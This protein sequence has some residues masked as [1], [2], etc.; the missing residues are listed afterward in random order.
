MQ[1]VATIDQVSITEIKPEHLH[2]VWGLVERGL[3]DVLRKSNLR[4]R[5]AD[6]IPADVYASIRTAQSTL[7]LVSRKTRL[8]GFFI[9]LQQRL[10]YSQKLELFNWV[11]WAI[12]LRERLPG[13]DIPQALALSQR[14]IVDLAQGMHAD[15][16]TFISSRGEK[17]YWEGLGYEQVYSIWKMKV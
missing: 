5:V 7:Y 13:D 17:K 10:P 1:R 12:P 4:H 16:V 3:I 8:L 9:L 11:T 15:A 14:F 2:A 6:W